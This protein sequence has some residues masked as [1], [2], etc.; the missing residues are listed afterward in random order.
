MLSYQPI[1]SEQ[2]FID[3]AVHPE[4]AWLCLYMAL[5]YN[6]CDPSWILDRCNWGVT[7][8]SQSVHDVLTGIRD[9]GDYL[10]RKLKT[11]AACGPNQ[12][13]RF[14]LGYSPSGEPCVI[15][16]QRQG[17]FSYG[18]GESL[19][20]MDIKPDN[21]GYFKD[22]VAVTIIPDPFYAQGTGVFPGIPKEQI[23]EERSW[24]PH[25]IPEQL[26]L[27]FK[28]FQMEPPSRLEIEMADNIRVVIGDL[29]RA[30]LFI[31]STGSIGDESE[32]ECQKYHVVSLP[33]LVVE[34]E[35]ELV[36]QAPGLLSPGK[37]RE[38]LAAYVFQLRLIFSKEDCN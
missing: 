9:Y 28:L 30:E 31:R 25:K 6:T 7:Y 14:E 4:K 26:K 21:N 3:S 10:K 38:R 36:M 19:L 11:I 8:T 20:W 37:I 22:I 33:N 23:I 34:H 16:Y 1:E 17:K 5:A 24:K 27:D 18:I 35:G 2:T 13:A 15:G 32:Y 29:P 12:R